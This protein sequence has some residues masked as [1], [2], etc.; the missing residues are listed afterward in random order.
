MVAHWDSRT[1]IW[2]AVLCVCMACLSLGQ[3]S[4]AQSAARPKSV[5]TVANDDGSTRI[6][7]TPDDWQSRR[8]S[9][10]AA[11]ES[12]MGTLP[13]AAARPP[14]MT[15]L[16]TTDMGTYLRA[17]TQVKTPV[18]AFLQIPGDLCHRERT[19]AKGN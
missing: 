11:M 4:R 6:A 5:L 18:A 17:D 12:V 14:R 9:I 10:V 2:F 19:T 13:D 3:R 16:E 8:H 7:T 1:R 15:V